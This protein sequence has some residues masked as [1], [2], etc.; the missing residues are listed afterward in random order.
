[1]TTN[2]TL[3]ATA[4]EEERFRYDDAYAQRA[5]RLTPRLVPFPPPPQEAPEAATSPASKHW[6]TVQGFTWTLLDPL[7]DSFEL[8]VAGRPLARLTIGGLAFPSAILE[9][10]EQRLLFAVSGVGTRRV[11]IA[12]ATTN[13]AVA[14]FEWQRLGRHGTLRLVDGGHLQWHKTGPWRPT[15]TFAD[16][17]GTLL[18]RLRPDGRGFGYGL[19]ALLE[20]PVGSPD[21]LMLL[22]A[23]GWFLLIS[24]GAAAP[25]EPAAMP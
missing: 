6:A 24:S 17:F 16:R 8:Q 23:L 22:P 21:D 15:F 13:T 19:H 12:D 11:A 7:R 5:R 9:A 18:L 3:D 4:A 2:Q 20:P 14:E 1:M 25:P 10:D